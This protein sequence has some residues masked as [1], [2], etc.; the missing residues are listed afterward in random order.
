M[1]PMFLIGAVANLAGLITFV[2]WAVLKARA[3]RQNQ[4]LDRSLNALEKLE[5]S[6]REIGIA[7]K[8][9]KDL[10][11]IKQYVDLL[12]E[13]KTELAKELSE[14]GIEMPREG[15]PK[16]RGVS[17][18]ALLTMVDICESNIRQA[19]NELTKV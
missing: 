19:K 7:I 10:L 11:E 2:D 8:E 5:V 15:L 9:K 18:E 12:N 16:V 6:L 13:A 14:I 1:E 17:D 4:P 3:K